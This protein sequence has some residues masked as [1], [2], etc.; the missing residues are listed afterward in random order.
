MR[1]FD[2]QEDAAN[3]EWNYS[4]IPDLYIKYTYH[5]IISELQSNNM[6][7]WKKFT[8]GDDNTYKMDP[9]VLERLRSLGYVR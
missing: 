4:I 3:L 9:D 5:K 7:A 1:L 6:L 8:G 2:F